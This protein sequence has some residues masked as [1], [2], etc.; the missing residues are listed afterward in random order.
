MANY[1]FL[2]LKVNTLRIIVI[3]SFVKTIG[4]TL[5]LLVFEMTK[6]DFN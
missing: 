5:E 4:L 2:Y 6:G 3:K 1:L